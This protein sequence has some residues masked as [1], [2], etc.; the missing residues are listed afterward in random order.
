ME[1]LQDDALGPRASSYHSSAFPWLPP[2]LIF[3]L[4]KSNIPVTVE[5]HM[6]A[7]ASIKVYGLFKKKLKS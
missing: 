7:E 4:L 2:V 3:L 5:K 6:K 1:W